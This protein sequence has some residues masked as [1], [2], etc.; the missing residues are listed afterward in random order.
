MNKQFYETNLFVVL[1][2]ILFFPLG[3]YLMFKRKSF[4]KPVRIAIASVFAIITV[5][6][7]LNQPA[8]Q[9]TTENNKAQE[10]ATESNIATDNNTQEKIEEETK[11]LTITEIV[12]KVGKDSVL[13]VN[14]GEDLVVKMKFPSTFSNSMSITSAFLKAKD[15]IQPSLDAGY[16]FNTYQFW[17]T[18]D[19]ADVYGNTENYK[20]LSFEYDRSTI[21]KINFNGI[22]NDNFEKLATNVYKHPAITK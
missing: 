15:I 10:T 12:N 21:E 14:T 7:V 2:L 11:P 18:A 6:S 13:E 17:F 1:A 22:T 8:T 16:E 3:L 19:L 4:N 5:A 9:N 20:V